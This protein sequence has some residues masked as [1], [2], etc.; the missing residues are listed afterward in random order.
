MAPSIVLFVAARKGSQEKQ[1]STLKACDPVVTLRQLAASILGPDA[2][3]GCVEA[4]AKLGG[5]TTTF[6]AD[7][8]GYTAQFL[9]DCGLRSYRSVRGDEPQFVTAWWA[10]CAFDRTMRLELRCKRL[11]LWLRSFPGPVVGKPACFDQDCFKQNKLLKCQSDWNS[12]GRP[13]HQKTMQPAR[14]RGIFV[15][16]T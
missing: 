5:E 1:K 11:L 10:S 13:A 9:Q 14:S 8:L 15:E 2:E 3:V 12:F 7:D 4:A 16:K 6:T